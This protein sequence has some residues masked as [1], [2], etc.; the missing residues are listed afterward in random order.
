MTMSGFGH[1]S[2][3]VGV[4]YGG[5]HPVAVLFDAQHVP[6]LRQKR[7]SALMKR[8]GVALF[9]YDLDQKRGV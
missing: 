8:A 9:G 5:A 4:S 1:V 2:T 6:D 3:A 7:D